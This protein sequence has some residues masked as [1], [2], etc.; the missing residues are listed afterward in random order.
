MV[1]KIFLSII[2]ASLLLC[3]IEGAVLFALAVHGATT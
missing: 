1:D 2:I 3:L